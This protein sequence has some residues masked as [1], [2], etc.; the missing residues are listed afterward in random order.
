MNDGLLLAIDA[1]TGSCRALLFDSKGNLVASAQQEYSH[2][3]I[4]GVEGSQQ[5]DID[6]NWK[7]I[8]ICV[9]EAMSRSGSPPDAVRAITA[10]SMRE[11]IVLYDARGRELWACPNVDARAASQVERLVSSGAAAEI[12]AHAGDWVAITAPARLL[13]I[14]ENEPETFASVEHV[15]MLGDWILYRLSGEFVTD[16]SLGIELGNV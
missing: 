15:T 14:A 3:A 6:A 5:F 12:Y 4:P 11:G 8:C 9:R 1:G 10:T 7:L 13:W 2:H 16:P